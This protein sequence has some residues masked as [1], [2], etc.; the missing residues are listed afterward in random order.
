MSGQ[1]G[2]RRPVGF[3]GLGV[4]GRPMARNLVRAGH[5]VVV[6]NRSA[7]PAAELAAA[8]ATVAR[9][10]AELAEA[11]PVVLTMLPDLPQVE[12]VLFR[13]DGLLRG[14]GRE[15]VLVVMGTVSPVDVRDLGARLAPSGVSVVD[16][17][18]SGGD[19]GAEQAT[20]SIMAGGR[21]QDVARV[22]PLLEA[23]GT[24]V[25]HLGPLGAGQLAKACNQ[26]VVAATLTALSEA[27]VLARKG[28]LDP[29]RVFA[30]LAGGLAGSR[31]LEV[32]G[33]KL[34]AGDFQP[35]GAAA[36]QHK[37]LGF[38]LAAARAEGVAL[39][40]TALV[41]QLFGAARWNGFGD[42]D[43]SVVVR[44]IERLAGEPRDG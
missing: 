34:L 21:E 4:M 44:V 2:G 26:I 14:M 10:P 3:V 13:E 29:Q 9:T 6:W 16:A 30:V 8:G 15:S 42:D 12:A 38:A 31:V 41:D 40:I 37:D 1:E 32:K 7:E 36:F 18:V 39:P 28:G 11:A 33:P 25:D 20:L 35:G 22:R 5:R 24:T 43:H 19:V 27:L 17:P 23:M